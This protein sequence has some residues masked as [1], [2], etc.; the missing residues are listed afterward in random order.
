MV[1]GRLIVVGGALALSAILLAGSPARGQI[2]PPTDA[3]TN[4]A[5]VETTD[6]GRT[7]VIDQDSSSPLILVTIA[8][9]I[10]A[11]LA[12]VFGGMCRA[13]NAAD[14]FAITLIIVPLAGL[15]CFVFGFALIWGNAAGSV[16]PANVAGFVGHLPEG[17][18]DRGIGFGTDA[19][20]PNNSAYG[21]A[22]TTGFFL[23][24]I[25]NSKLLA[26]F[27]ITM[28][29]AVISAIIPAG[30]LAER[31][32]W[33]NCVL[34]AIWFVVPFSLFANWVW[35][36]GW[37]AQMGVNWGWGH[38]AIDFAGSGVIHALGGVVGLAG[39]M[40]I[41][42][43]IG[44]FVSGRPRPIPGHSIPFVVLGTLVLVP[45]WFGLTSAMNGGD[46][47]LSR[48]L[49]NTA[50]AGFS[51]TTGALLFLLSRGYKPDPTLLCNGFIGGLVAISAACPFVD[52]WAAIV[53]GLVA[54][55]VVNFSV[56]LWDKLG[57]DDPVG[58]VSMHGACGIW[59]LLALGLFANGKFGANFNGVDG[60][61]KGLFY[62]DV[63]QFFAQI[64]AAAILTIFG[65]IT[66]LVLFRL[67]ERV[68]ALRVSADVE[69]RGLDT[70]EVGT[71]AYPD[72]M[73]K[74]ATLDG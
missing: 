10:P 29:G 9:L 21:F 60:P 45:G 15:A 57:V 67:S 55:V 72:F 6:G 54:G 51:G 40:C 1:S 25:D 66:A 69:M 4:A 26:M 47:Q 20:H 12:L 61:V 3:P 11:G 22:G 70:S 49:V 71:F 28:A 44:K 7:A 38:G 52:S 24:G 32:T 56:L 48:I 43:R 33:K 13:K 63:G 5:A 19:N 2:N 65:F 18:L 35:G 58:V 31:W 59:G 36:G 53:A 30:A 42:P 16:L 74:S 8:L 73:L 17:V 64:V 27:L 68:A 37:L 14:A 41:G 50:L 39:A 34:Y 46:L 23:S 62:G